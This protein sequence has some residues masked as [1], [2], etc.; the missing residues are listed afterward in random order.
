MQ[1][2]LD[3][4]ARERGHC[5]RDAAVHRRAQRVHNL[6]DHDDRR[7]LHLLLLCDVG[8]VLDRPDHGALSRGGRALDD[9]NRRARGVSFFLELRRQLAQP[10]HRHQKHARLVRV[11]RGHVGGAVVLAVASHEH[12][13]VGHAPMGHRDPGCQRP[14]QSRGDPR[15]DL[16]LEAEAPE[17]KHFLPSPAKDEGVPDLETHDVLSL[18]ES[19]DAP[20]EDLALSFVRAAW[21]LPGHLELALHQLQDLR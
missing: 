12:H 14:G 6:P 13:T 17:L 2:L 5:L 7:R 11:E 8:N 9:P 1:Q 21:E 3:E 20:A 16:G 15:D 4:L 19:F 10:P 18:E